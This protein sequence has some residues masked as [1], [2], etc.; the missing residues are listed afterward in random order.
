MSRADDWQCSTLTLGGLLPVIVC[1]KKPTC[2][3]N[4][5]YRFLRSDVLLA[6]AADLGSAWLLENALDFMLSAQSYAIDTLQGNQQNN[7]LNILS[8]LAPADTGVQSNHIN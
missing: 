2:G 4:R 1:G 8:S 6:Y 3:N 5:L 7:Q